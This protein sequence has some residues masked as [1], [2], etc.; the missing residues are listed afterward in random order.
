MVMGRNDREPLKTFL[1][2]KIGR[3]DEIPDTVR[4]D[5]KICIC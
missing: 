2:N 1:L 3:K 4:R 5:I